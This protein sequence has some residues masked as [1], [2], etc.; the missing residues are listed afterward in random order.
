MPLATPSSSIRWNS[1]T[2]RWFLPLCLV[3]IIAT[4]WL[5]PYRPNCNALARDDDPAIARVGSECILLSDYAEPLRF[6]ETAIEYAESEFLSDAPNLDYMRLWYDRVTFYG[7]ETIALAGA[8]SQSALYQRAVAEGHTPAAEEVA[9]IINRDRRRAEASREILELA[10]LA[11][12]SDLTEF[13][14]LLESSEHPDLETMRETMDVSQLAESFGD[15][16]EAVFRQYEESLAQWDQYR[17]SVGPE[18]YWQEILPAKL[19]REMSIP[20]LEDSVLEASADGPYREVPRLAWLAYQQEVFDGASIKLTDAAPVNADL[21]G[22]L[23]YLAESR[24]Q[25]IQALNE[26]YRRLLERRD[27]RQRRQ[28]L[29]PPPPSPISN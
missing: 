6:T 13:R 14:E 17:E 10:T 8:I 4:V 12:K 29:T 19:R 24:E 28:R 2:R 5:L 21:A 11:Q 26:E 22:A 27:E 18:R 23:D 25:E 1:V 16:E 20:K 7:P 15:W 3:V 9:L